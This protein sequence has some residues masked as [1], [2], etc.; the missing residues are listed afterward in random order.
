[1]QV[2]VAIATKVLYE[3]TMNYFQFQRTNASEMSIKYY[4]FKPRQY[5]CKFILQNGHYI[6]SGVSL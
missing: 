6:V 2:I 5:I 3:P 4:T 1:M